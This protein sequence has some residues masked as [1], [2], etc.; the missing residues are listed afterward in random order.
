MNAA[1]RRRRRRRR[2]GIEFVATAEEQEEEEEEAAEGEAHYLS[3]RS[4]RGGRGRCG[5][6]GGRGGG[7]APRTSGTSRMAPGPAGIAGPSTTPPRR[8]ESPSPSPSPPPPPSRRPASS[9][10]SSLRTCCRPP[11]K[12]PLSSA[13]APLPKG[14]LLPSR[15][16]GVGP[17]WTSKSWKPQVNFVSHGAL[18][19]SKGESTR[20]HR[21]PP[22]GS[23]SLTWAQRFLAVHARAPM[24]WRHVRA[25]RGPNQNR[26]PWRRGQSNPCHPGYGGGSAGGT[27]QRR[28]PPHALKD[29]SSPHGV[30]GE[31][32]GL[33]VAAEIKRRGVEAG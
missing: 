16:G 12:S 15:P 30:K 27:P 17:G 5:G 3:S 11:P 22:I 24:F 31:A 13:P 7:A 9:P 26:R 19:P 6:G 10:P 20:R 33:W 18:C 29:L 21:T 1:G 4:R 2:E 23:S 8:R 25:A 28:A 14:F 32:S